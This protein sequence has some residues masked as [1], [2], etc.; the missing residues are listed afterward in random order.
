MMNQLKQLISRNLFRHLLLCTSGFLIITLFAYF[1]CS[2]VISGFKD[3]SVYASNLVKS[4]KIR[5]IKIPDESEKGN[6]GNDQY[7]TGIK[8]PWNGEKLVVLDPGHGGIDPGTMGSGL[9]EKEVSLSI[10][11]KV[12][13]LLNA[14]GI[15][16]IMTRDDDSFVDLKERIDMANAKNAAIFLSIHCNWF[17]DPSLRGSMTLYYPSDTLSAGGL[18]EVDYAQ[19]IEN[20]LGKIPDTNELG[21]V[22]RPNLAVL[23]HANM[24]SIIA[25]LGFLSNTKDAQILGSE[26]YRQKYALALFKGVKKALDKID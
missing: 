12:T 7:T 2:W 4:G 9:T 16:T 23:H 18:F 22:A 11:L 3:P 24:P 17:S 15:Q 8:T 25:E 13:A 21:I 14:S 20:E 19:I 1:P 5:D 6:D 10:A 26:S